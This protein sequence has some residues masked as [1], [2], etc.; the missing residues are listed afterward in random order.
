MINFLQKITS[1]IKEKKAN[2]KECSLGQSVKNKEEIKIKKEELKEN[3]KK[4][5]YLE[6]GR[7]SCRERV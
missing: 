6:I 7:A 4:I 5:E 3:L 1:F 2:V